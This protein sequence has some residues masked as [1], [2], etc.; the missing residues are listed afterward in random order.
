MNIKSIIPA[1]STRLL[2]LSFLLALLPISAYPANVSTTELTLKVGGPDGVIEVSPEDT[3]FYINCTHQSS[4]GGQTWVPVYSFTVDVTQENSKVIVRPK[5]AGSTGFTIVC[6]DGTSFYIS[7]FVRAENSFTAFTEEGVEMTFNVTDEES[8][9]CTVAAKCIDLKT[10]GK[11]SVPSDVNGYRVTGIEY[12]AFQNCSQITEVVLPESVSYISSNYLFRG[13]TSL[14]SVYIPKNLVQVGYGWFMGCESL[15]S[16]VV[17]PENTSLDSRDNCNAIIKTYSNSMVS[18]CPA[19]IIPETVTN[20]AYAAFNNFSSLESIYIPA[21]VTSIYGW[22]FKNCTNLKEITFAKSIADM[23]EGRIVM[24]CYS[25]EKVIVL[26]EN[27]CDII[28]NAFNTDWDTWTTATLYVPAG[29]KAKYEAAAGWNKFS[30]IVELGATSGEA[31]DLGLPSGL[32]WASFNVGASKPEEYGCYYAWG[33]TEEKDVYGDWTTYKWSNGSSD[34][35]TKYCTTSSQGSV[36]NKTVL[37]LEDDVAHVKWG[38]NWRM[39][40]Q[41]EV[42]ELLDN[43]TSEWTNLNGVN[44]RK[45]TSKTNGNSIFLPATGVFWDSGIFNAG[46]GGWYWS[47]SLYESN[48]YRSFDLNFG[49]EDAGCYNNNRTDGRT[50]RPVMSSS[51][52]T[53][54]EAYAVLTDEGQTVTFYYDGKKAERNNVV[55][56]QHNYED[57]FYHTATQAIFDASMADYQPSS[58]TY[59]FCDCDKL[60]NI[61]GIEYLNTENVTDMKYMFTGCSSLTSLDVSHFDTGNV[62]DMRCLFKGC[63]V[64]TSLDVSHFDTEKVTDMSCMFNDC[65][66]LTNLDVS[67]FDTKNVTDMNYMFSYCTK[68]TNLDVS[69]F[70][71]E[72]VKD[73]SAM[74]YGCSGLTEIDVSHFDTRNVTDMRYLFAG[75]SGLTSLDVSHFDTRNVTSMALMFANSSGLTSIDVSH[76]DTG[77]VTDMV[78]MF[79]NCSSLTILNVNNFDTGNVTDMDYMFSLC[80]SLTSLDLSHFST[81][82]VTEAEG[83]FGDCTALKTI[84]VDEGWTTANMGKTDFMFANCTGLIGGKGTTYSDG[85]IDATYAH[86]DGGV[87][88][89]GYFTAK[90]SD[91]EPMEEEGKVRIGDEMTEGTNL[92]NTVIDNVYYS[93]TSNNGGFD[94][95]EGCITINTPTDDADATGN[96][97]SKD[98]FTGMVME[99]PA[100]SGK[101]KV[102]A[103]TSG[104]MTLKVRIGT[105][106]PLEFEL[107]G[108]LTATF[109]YTVTSPTFVYIYAGTQN[110]A[111]ARGEVQQNAPAPEGSLKIYDFSWEFYTPTSL[112]GDIDGNNKVDSNDVITLAAFLTGLS[113][114]E[115]PTKTADVNGDG[116]VNVA[117]L[118]S[119]IAIIGAKQ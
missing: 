82:K 115:L 65:L 36:D 47:S 61:T 22:E 29:C 42:N 9:E 97:K 107:E 15:R 89:P 75:C 16:V 80:H 108:K 67:H 71:T 28:E 86:I 10:T 116:Y 119:I 111:G 109:P 94:T 43:T 48:P 3:Y 88:G 11:I 92:D 91:I 59:W 46:S 55:E 40:T 2:L 106:A 23:G 12:E 63:Y 25:L 87:E 34:S 74:F 85:H 118:A 31:I 21:S 1:K 62:T 7:I 30:D 79:Q 69:N 99:V 4:D 93:I 57:N 70:S 24:G 112:S 27:P 98:G 66:I 73:I 14:E 49:S 20:L 78:A 53:E 6:N 81:G 19:T 113:S 26:D 35:L 44:G 33:E 38:G 101:V 100:G 41:D 51:Q 105:G 52:V 39:P 68:L 83:M 45:F 95:S 37:D 50:V 76:F 114:G 13:C 117:D 72:N 102:T 104:T 54:K 5:V 84:Y 60:T 64:L 110:A 90:S 77:N 8:K 56:I 18:A 17:D 103:Q 96:V 58:T 32:K